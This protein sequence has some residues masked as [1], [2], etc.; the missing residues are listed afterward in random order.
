M[1]VKTAK[2][3]IF[4]DSTKVSSIASSIKTEKDTAQ[5]PSL[6][7]NHLLP[8]KNETPQLHITNYDFRITGILLLLYI[9]FVWLYVSNRKRLNQIIKAFYINRYG[10]QLT[11]DEIAIG[12]RV[13]IFLS[14][15]FIVTI[16]IFITHLL[17]YY[18]FKPFTSNIALFSIII[19]FLLIAGYGIKF[20]TIKTLGYIFKIQKEAAEYAMLVFLFCNTLGLFML[21][22]VVGLIFMRQISPAVFIH[23]GIV[24]IAIF[25]AVRVIRGLFMGLNSSRISKFYLF[26]YLCT[27][28]ILPFIILAKLFMLEFR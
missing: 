22:L 23:T 6:F 21:P 4:S 7:Q 1:P 27:L 28:E 19:A 9:L 3:I 13:A 10:S 14:L 20:L 26:M 5:T 25:I 17:T 2:N 11:R 24:I 12:N 8:V 18:G 16:T 15:F